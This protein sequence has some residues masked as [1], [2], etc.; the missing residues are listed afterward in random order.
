MQTK[1][2]CCVLRSLKFEFLFIADYQVS[3]S[4]DNIVY[5]PDNMFSSLTKL[6]MYSVLRCIRWH[7]NALL[8]S[9][10]QHSIVQEVI[11]AFLNIVCSHFATRS[12]ITFAS[13][14]FF[15][16]PWWSGT[17]LIFEFAEISKNGKIETVIMPYLDLQPLS[18]NMNSGTTSSPLCVPPFSFTES[19][20][21]ARIEYLQKFSGGTNIR[22]IG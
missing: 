1:Q 13:L 6:L 21:K 12:D 7:Y 8:Y 18:S 3:I 10:V 2:L 9:A 4:K 5:T 14:I 20:L 15:Y 16:F 19:D 17:S 11:A 22:W